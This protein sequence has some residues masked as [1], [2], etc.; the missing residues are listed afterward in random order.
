MGRP[1]LYSSHLTVVWPLEP[2]GEVEFG[3]FL[4]VMT[5]SLQKMA[6]SKKAQKAQVPFAL[7][8]TAYKRKKL[9]E[10]V[11]DGTAETW[12]EI[13]I[14]QQEAEKAQEAEQALQGA[15]LGG[16][17]GKGSLCVRESER[18]CER[19]AWQNERP[20]ALCLVQLN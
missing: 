6:D 16:D 12:G 9:L 14:A 11:V 10:G 2:P 3:E 19:G 8:T 5:V 15:I 1:S 7:I 17:G 18:V 20:C 13:V 4:E